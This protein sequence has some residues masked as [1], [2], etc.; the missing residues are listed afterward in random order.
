MRTKSRQYAKQ[1]ALSSR[2]VSFV[3]E[4]PSYWQN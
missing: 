4:A 1:K 3:V 2:F